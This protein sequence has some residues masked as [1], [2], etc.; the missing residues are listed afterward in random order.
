MQVL[1]VAGSPAPGRLTTTFKLGVDTLIDTGAA[2][3]ALAPESWARIRHVL[4]SHSHLDHTLGLPFLAIPGTP[5]V[6][7]LQETL[8][9]VRESLL[10]GRIWPDLSERI[11][12]VEI[13]AGMSI[14]VGGRRVA[15]GPA[16]HTVPCLSFLVDGVVVVG[17]T[18]LDDEVI[19]WAAAQRP[20]TCIVE[21][22]FADD[23]HELAT[24]LGHQTP[25]DLRPWR[26]ALGPDCTLAVTHLKPEAG[27][28]I[29]TECE[30]F[31]DPRLRILQD[32]DE[33]E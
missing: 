26:E 10:D 5:R 6:Y 18:R 15:I 19:A 7:G 2:P 14:D 23:S 9:A 8:D 29:R 24:R 1:G 28:V 12:W 11:E 4:L 33:I 3:F 20:R 22:S 17:D 16:S 21:C 13:E 30:A 25:R 31:S 27:A 32:G